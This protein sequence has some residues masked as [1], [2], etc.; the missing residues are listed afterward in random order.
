[1]TYHLKT[2]RPL[3]ESGLL[4]GLASYYSVIYIIA[5]TSVKTFGRTW[6]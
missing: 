5:L 2:T 3:T 4:F 1:M 6:G